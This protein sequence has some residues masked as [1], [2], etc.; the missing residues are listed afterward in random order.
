M[1]HLTLI[2][3]QLFLLQKVLGFQKVSLNNHNRITKK[4]FWINNTAIDFSW[5]IIIIYLRSFKILDIDPFWVPMTEEELTDLGDKAERENVAYK[6]MEVVRKRK[7]LFV[8]K[9]IVEFAE[10]QKTMKNK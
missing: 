5:V 10:K 6:Y 7:G 1:E 9:K 2:L 4:N 3:N 8:E